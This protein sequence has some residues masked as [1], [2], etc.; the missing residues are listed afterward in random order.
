MAE[1]HPTAIINKNAQLGNDVVIGPYVTIDGSVVIGDRTRIIAHAHIS[2][3]TEIG[4]DCVIHPFAAIGGPPQDYAFGGERSYCR[5]GAGNEIREYVSIHRGTKPETST[6]IGAGCYFMACS[7]VAHN[8]EVGDHVILTNAALLGGYVKVGQRAVVGGGG[9]AHQF[10][11]IGE[12]AMVGGNCT[13]VQ[14]ALPFMVY[15]DR[16]RCFG[17]NRVG[18]RRNG[19]SNEEVNELRELHRR[20]LRQ[21]GNIRRTAEEIASSVQTSPGKRLIEFI[22]A[23]SKRG[24]CLRSSSTRPPTE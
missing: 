12:F 8:C 20:L 23:E 22:L 19:F 6:V 21:S 1:I 24:L 11:R 15:A 10:C 14:D 5:I 13:L 17:L 18:L 2:G 3:H 7:H 4:E 9:A 16:N